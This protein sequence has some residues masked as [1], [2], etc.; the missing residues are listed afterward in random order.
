MF[1]V[2]HI[3]EIS[4]ELSRSMIISDHIPKDLFEM[5]AMLLFNTNNPKLI[6][7]ISWILIN[8][9]H[10]T[11]EYSN[12]L[13]SDEY[14]KPLFQLLRQTSEVSIQK[15]LFWIFSNLFSEPNSSILFSKIDIAIYVLEYI[16]KEAI[17]YS[18]K[19]TLL[20]LIGVLY[21][22][23]NQSFIIMSRN[24]VNILLKYITLV[25]NP[26]LFSEAIEMIYRMIEAQDQVI[27]EKVNTSDLDIPSILVKYMTPDT[28]YNDLC[29]IYKIVEIMCIHS[30][31]FGVNIKTAGFL[32]NTDKVFDYVSESY[33]ETPKK[34]TKECICNIIKAMEDY[35][36]TDTRNA[37]K[38]IR[39]TDAL[40]NMM[41]LL[42]KN[43][44][45]INTSIWSFL[46]TAV[47]QGDIRVTTEIFRHN[48]LQ[49]VCQSLNAAET[50][51]LLFKLKLIQTLLHRG[52]EYIKDYNVVKDQMEQ[53]G[54]D[55]IIEQLALSQDV[56]ISLISSQII[57]TY[58]K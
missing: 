44:P 48:L 20:W 53:M 9:T 38:I 24:Y 49:V 40:K 18:L 4:N 55:T 23:G 10:N 11:N 2:F 51:G 33:L 56:E 3:R 50:S 5:I 30:N 37:N 45:E 54:T 25:F 46:F 12:F 58:F 6:Y 41:N 22:T 34:V 29:N 26:E 36:T 8:I 47:N 42:Q 52:T 39:H 35:I 17:P 13:M 16:S 57:E 27:L 15:H 1:A 14:I 19:D 43:T 31:D 7:E 21:K 28:P 32:D